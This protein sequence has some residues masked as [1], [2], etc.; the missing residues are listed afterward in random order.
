MSCNRRSAQPLTSPAAPARLPSTSREGRFALCFRC[1]LGRYRPRWRWR[2]VGEKRGLVK[3]ADH[4]FR[5]RGYV[6]R[7][8]RSHG[9]G[10]GTRMCRSLAAVQPSRCCL[11]V[12]T[13]L[14]QQT[15]AVERPVKPHD[16]FSILA[17][18]V[19]ATRS[20]CRIPAGS[21]WLAA[22]RAPG[23]GGPCDR[24]AR[25]SRTRGAG[26]PP[27]ITRGEDASP[28]PF[29]SDTPPSGYLV[30]SGCP[31]TPPPLRYIKVGE[32]CTI[33]VDRL[34]ERFV[35]KPDAGRRV[36][37]SEGGYLWNAGIFIGGLRL[38]HR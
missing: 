13:S 31:S 4:S 30:R 24:P 37:L 2:E 34:V 22:C 19:R 18:H 21:P 36:F 38:R 33:R 32:G 9:G 6:S 23:F 5:L 16:L 15:W 10:V 20:S 1:R 25:G 14:L 8:S 28:P 27:T 17:A 7:C 12:Y 35:E 3:G 26:F 29:G 11:T